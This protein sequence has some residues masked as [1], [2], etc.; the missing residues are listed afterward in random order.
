MRTSAHNS[1]CGQLHKLHVEYLVAMLGNSNR[2]WNFQAFT[3]N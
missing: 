1:F 3:Q 2:Y